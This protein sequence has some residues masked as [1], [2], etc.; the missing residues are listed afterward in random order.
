MF[1][2]IVAHKF[3][4]PNAPQVFA[5]ILSIQLDR[6]MADILVTHRAGGLG[7]KSVN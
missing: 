5:W 6:E 3:K 2:L 7:G 1:T 4:I